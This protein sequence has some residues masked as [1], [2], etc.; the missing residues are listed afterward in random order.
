VI[1]ERPDDFVGTL[2][3]ACIRNGDIQGSGAKAPLV[4]P[5]RTAVEVNMVSLTP[6]FQDMSY[7][8]RFGPMPHEL[9]A[10]TVYDSLGLAR[11]RAVHFIG[12]R[13]NRRERDIGLSAGVATRTRESVELVV[14][15]KRFAQAV[16]VN[17]PGYAADDNYFHLLPGEERLIL[18]HR[19]PEGTEAR[20][21]GGT[22][23]AL[24]SESAATV[25]LR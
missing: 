16:H 11:G 21:S 25:I 1:N 24:N 2:E 15:T 14:S 3:I 9:V 7:S 12:H 22:V 17:V 5:S 4:V 13:P 6:G 18:L 23:R 19:L 8:Y 10:A 20:E